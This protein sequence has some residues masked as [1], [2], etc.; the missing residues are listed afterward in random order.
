MPVRRV[1]GS[2]IGPRRSGQLTLAADNRREHDDAVATDHAMKTARIWLVVGLLGVLAG[3]CAPTGSDSTTSTSEPST[4][5]A[6]DSTTTTIAVS[7]TVPSSMTS[8]TEGMTD[9]ANLPSAL[10]RERVTWD[11]VGAGW[12]VVLYDSSKAYPTSEAD[13]REGPLVLYLVN[14]GGERY[15]VAAW[16][17]GEFRTLV[18]ATATSALVAGSGANLDE[19]V[20]EVVDLTTGSSSVAFTVGFSESSFVNTWPPLSLTRPSG[21][22]VVIHRSNGTTD[23][24][25]RRAADGTVL[26]VVYEQT[27]VEGDGS[28]AWL[29]GADGTSLIVAATGGIFEMTNE[30]STLGE[31]WAP[32][33]TRCEPVRWWDEDTFL[34]ACYGQGP[35]SAPL[36][37]YGQPHTY[38]GRLWLLET[39]GSTGAPL[40]EYPA[41]PPIVVDF[42]YHDAW[43]TDNE[44]YIEWSGDCGS[45]AVATL[46][47]DGTGELLDIEEPEARLAHGV[48]VI[49][50]VDGQ[51]TVYGWDDCAAT[52]GGLF[53]TDLEGRYLNTLVP[54]IG[55]SRGVIGVRGLAT[56]YP[57]G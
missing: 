26:S 55:D 49:D 34:A 12:Y 38:Y 6:T 10:S 37:D 7:T 51:M 32:P 2:G 3:G 4:T 11:D 41:E 45:S 25:E 42:G 50:I 18:D 23:W 29:Y 13:V 57:S 43:P 46:T 44:T 21:A 56:V 53:T 48:E 35:D 52:V 17:P 15:E 36:D 33:D 27:Y 1:I 9:D 28:M 40:T 8:T 47:A 39:D 54:V 14:S 16:Q 20:F 24:L 31:L 5:T 22:N 30:G 19:T